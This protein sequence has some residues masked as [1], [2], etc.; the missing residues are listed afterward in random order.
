MAGKLATAKEAAEMG[1]V[2]HVVPADRLLD[3]AL[4]YAREL[5]ARPKPAVRWTKMVINQVVQQNMNLMLSLGYASEL[6]SAHTEDQK[7]AVAAFLE[8]RAPKFTGE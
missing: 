8:K 7:E 1:L 4:A 2:N 6:L 3:E 5:V